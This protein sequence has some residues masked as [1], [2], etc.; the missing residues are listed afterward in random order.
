MANKA[1]IQVDKK[2]LL[3]VQR[4]L[5]KLFPKTSQVNNAL[6]RGLRKA[7]RPIKQELKSL[8]GKSAFKTGK[9]ARS[10]RVFDSKRNTKAGRPSV[11]VGPLVKVPKKIKNN[12]GMT[13]AEK[14]K[15]SDAFI[16]EKSGY[17][18]YMLEYGF[19]PG[20]G[21]TKVMGLGLRPKAVQKAGAK[22]SQEVINGV[23]EIINKQAMKTLNKKLIN[24]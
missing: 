12:K 6:R 16:K 10:I 11:F 8:I 1:L 4:G 19:R 5:E 7:A 2:A 3:E 13:M 18:M 14:K 23:V 17:Y 9:L 22:A 20:G 21:K 24:L 15:A